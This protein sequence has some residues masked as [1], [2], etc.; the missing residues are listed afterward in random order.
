MT[1]ETLHITL[2]VWRQDGPD[3]RGRFETYDAPNV[4][5][6]MS[7]LEMLDVVNENL[8]DDG[9]E[10]IAFESDCREGICG[11]CDLMIDGKAH[12]PEKGTATCQLHMRKYS[13]GFNELGEQ[14][15]AYL[16]G[17]F[18]IAFDSKVAHYSGNG[19]SRNAAIQTVKEDGD[20]LSYLSYGFP[21]YAFGSGSDSSGSPSNDLTFGG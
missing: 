12:G 4:G 19:A 2:K 20:Y 11:T 18:H 14:G 13:D 17:A 5:T 8:N 3:E 6:D 21:E 9:K 15:R 1:E 16:K 10:P 7:F